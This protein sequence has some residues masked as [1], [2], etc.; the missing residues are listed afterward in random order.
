MD[1]RDVAGKNSARMTTLLIFIFVPAGGIRFIFDV[2][3]S[4]PVRTSTM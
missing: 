4:C 3:D 2:R 1:T